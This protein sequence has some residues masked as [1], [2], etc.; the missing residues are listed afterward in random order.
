M[1][2]V[3]FPGRGAGVLVVRGSHSEWSVAAGHCCAHRPRP[4][5]PGSACRGESSWETLRTCFSGSKR[6]VE[7]SI[8]SRV[9]LIAGI[10][11]GPSRRF[12][13]STPPFSLAF[14]HTSPG[15]WRPGGRGGALPDPGADLGERGGRSLLTRLDVLD[16]KSLLAA[17]ELPVAQQERAIMTCHLSWPS[18]SGYYL[19]ARPRATAAER[20]PPTHWR[21]VGR[22]F[23]WSRLETEFRLN[24]AQLRT[25]HT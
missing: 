25:T 15:R 2:R 11:R 17:P 23:A 6:P 19:H 1:A 5:R 24:R 14:R 3:T 18:P 12:V 13:R 7:T 4:W 9:G 8:R 10:M 16:H 21:I 22:A 20:I